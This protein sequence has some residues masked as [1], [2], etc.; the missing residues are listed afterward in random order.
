MKI[1]VIQT[2]RHEAGLDTASLSEGTN[3]SV[4]TLSE[5]SDAVDEAARGAVDAIILSEPSPEDAKRGDFDR[6]VRQLETRRIVAIVL[7][8]DPGSHQRNADSLVERVARA[9]SADELR[10]RLAMIERYHG[11]LKGLERELERME[12]LGRRISNQFREI[13]VELQ[14]AGRLQRDFLPRIDG[15]IRNL[16]ISTIYK[17]A[18]WVSGDMFDI[19][20]IDDDRTGIYLADAVGHGAAAGLLTMFLKRAIV[21]TGVSD[22]TGP[23]ADPSSVIT[24]LNDALL[25][26]KLPNS[27]FVTAGYAVFNHTTRML[28]YARGGHPYPI[29]I[30]R[31]GT[32]DEIK[33][34][35]G[36]L[37]LF[38]DEEYDSVEVE[39]RPGDK[40]LFYTDGVELAF[41]DPDGNDDASAYRRVFAEASS[42]PIAEMIAR[43]DAK[44]NTGSNSLSPRDDVTIVGMQVLDR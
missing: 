35:G 11:V 34:P 38:V 23:L 19:V 10:G 32:M 8:D 17:P 25:E 15:P 27:Q 24:S 37:G 43:I 18:S 33:V 39:L 30:G 40:V 21:P 14:L 20:R 42:L 3:W 22:P 26:Q 13:D 12:R 2:D 4:T 6:L 41:G 1:L 5:Y 44:L 31:D 36:L 28:K 29:R 9:I 16:A 7:A